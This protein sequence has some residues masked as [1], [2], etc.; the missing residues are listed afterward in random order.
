MAGDQLLRMAGERLTATVDATD[1]V[2]RLGGD[3]FAVLR[4]GSASRGELIA[5]AVRI[6]AALSAPFPHDGTLATIGVSIGIAVAPEM[7]KTAEALVRAADV[8]LYRAKAEGETHYA[9]AVGDVRQSPR[10]GQR[11]AA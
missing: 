4:H 6:R 1:S 9:F 10:R 7:A 8:A 2:A 11:T 3:E 5:L